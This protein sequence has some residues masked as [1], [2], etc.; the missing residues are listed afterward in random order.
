MSLPDTA[1][2]ILMT[3]MN[4]PSHMAVPPDRLPVAARRSVVMSMIKNN[5]LEQ[6]AAEDDQ[7]AWCTSDAGEQFAFRATEAGLQA[8][9]PA[10]VIAL[11]SAD[12]QLKRMVA[13]AVIPTF[14][15]G[16]R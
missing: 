1:R 14:D 13:A 10:E 4:H 3:A 7:P 5:L 12:V 15:H 8:V 11:V 2:V 6:V 16:H 9:A